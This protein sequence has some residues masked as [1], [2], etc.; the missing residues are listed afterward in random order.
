MFA[1]F[2]D[3]DLTKFQKLQLVSFQTLPPSLLLLLPLFPIT[4]ITLPITIPHYQLP[5]T[6]TITLFKFAMHSQQSKNDL[7]CRLA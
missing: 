3:V 6:T 1:A 4:T 5:I 7:A 2:D